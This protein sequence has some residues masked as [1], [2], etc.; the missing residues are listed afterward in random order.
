MDKYFLKARLQKNCHP[1]RSALKMKCNGLGQRQSKPT[2][3]VASGNGKENPRWGLTER[4]DHM[5]E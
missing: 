3:D 2:S 5:Q 4:G 1:D